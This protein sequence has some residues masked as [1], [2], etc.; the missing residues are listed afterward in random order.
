M[1]RLYHALLL[2][3]LWTLLVLP[4]F[5]TGKITGS[6]TDAE[7]GDPLPGVNVILVGTTIGT[8]TDF[9]GNYTI[10]NIPPGTYQ[11]QYSL[12]GFTRTI[13]DNVRVNTD[14]TTRQDVVLSEEVIQGQ[15]IVVVAERPLV[16]K[17]QT[18]SAAV[19]TAEELS[20]LPVEN[21]SEAVR[22]QTGV[23]QGADGG[24]HIRGGRANEISYI[25]DGIAVTDPFS[26][27]IGV[28]VEN[29]AIEELTVVSGT[30]N[31]EF[32]QAQSGVINI[33]TKN[34]SDS[35]EGSF[36]AFTGSYLSDDD[37][38]LRIGSVRPA[39]VTDFQGSLSGP[40]PGIKKLNFFFSGRLLNDDGYIWGQRWFNVGDDSDFSSPDAAD[41][42]VI[43]TGDSSDVSLNRE[44]NVTVQGKLTYRPFT[45]ATVT[46][47]SSFNETEFRQYDHDFKYNPDGDYTNR[48]EGRTLILNW[49]HALSASTFYVLRAAQVYSEQN[50]FVFEDPVDPRYALPAL[51]ERPPLNFASGGTKPDHLNRFTRTNTFKAEITSQLTPIHLVK[52]GIEAKRHELD[53]QSFLV[54][55]NEETGIPSVDPNVQGPFGRDEYNIKPFEFAAFIQD[56]I[57][58]EQMIVNVGV[59]FDYFDSRYVLP[60]DLT[61]PTNSARV[62]NEIKWQVSPRIGV[63]YPISE[64][65]VLYFSYGH[66]F[67]IP[68]FEFLYSNPE[69]EV[70][71]GGLNSIVG[72]ANLEPE[73][74]VAY[75]FGLQQ[76]LTESIVLETVGFYKDIRNLLGTEIFRTNQQTRYARYTNRDF[77]NVRGITLSLQ[78]RKGRGDLI[79]VGLDYT[80]SV[81]EGNASDPD[82]VFLDNVSVPP[83]ESESQLVSLDWDQRHTMNAAINIGRNTWDVGLIGRMGSG[84][85]YT[86]TPFGQRTTAFPENSENKPLTSIVDLQASK[87]FQRGDTSI[88]L[89]LKV[90][91][92]LDRRNAIDVY[93]DTGKAD[94]TIIQGRDER[95]VVI[96][97]LDDF[98]NRLNFYDP[99][100]EIRVGVGVRF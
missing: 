9:D 59:R 82:A 80:F 75:E 2:P 4:A 100:R 57:E 29:N 63:A 94:A 83:L 33:T 38:Y 31:A 98:I 28:Q 66:F 87:G 81:A 21:F 77:G 3:V 36:Q 32:G 67:Q 10:I 93:S 22:L 56:K 76:Q 20:S 73:Q 23:V 60:S 43:A 49:N 88:S 17:D 79:G 13:I 47:S 69:F 92:L 50:R 70:Q 5:G 39:S 41:W 46:L 6:V 19:V 48:R 84:Q 44:E 35:Y 54:V 96:S 16:V 1:P 51:L 24:I 91:N 95:P 58:L 42:N 89:F 99:P 7:T 71:T 55:V 68:P 85:P 86:P 97:T 8:V 14:F 90:F 40:V 62:D 45:G 12:I 74:T 25:V 27:G 18:S 65:G 15:E 52:G 30:F 37:R 64:R 53:F 26:G 78:K 11:V 34:G 61:D 72:N